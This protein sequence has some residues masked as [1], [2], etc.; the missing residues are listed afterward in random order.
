MKINHSQPN[1]R[2]IWNAWYSTHGRD[3]LNRDE[4]EWLEP[5]WHLIEPAS[6]S[7]LDLGSGRG[8]GSKYLTGMG[9]RVI[10]ADYAEEALR[11]VPTV[12]SSVMPIILDMR[13]DLPFP[14]KSF[15]IVVAG[16]S[17]HYYTWDKTVKILDDI[18]HKLQGGGCL[19]ARVNAKSDRAYLD[20]VA[21]NQ[22]EIEPDYRLVRG[23]PRRFFDEES[24][25]KLLSPGWEILHLVEK[26]VRPYHSLK[27]VWEFVCRKEV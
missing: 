18:Y 9:K 26:T 14:D 22:P 17:L 5:W 13:A 2:S 21:Q 8:L 1:S 4:G 16:L 7:I 24:L 3:N 10:A 23:S 20:E 19:I 12:A 27:N 6:S 25:L 15:D 11:I